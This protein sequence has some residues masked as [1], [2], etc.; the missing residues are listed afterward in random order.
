MC[1]GI[2]ATQFN[3]STLSSWQYLQINVVVIEYGVDAIPRQE[4]RG[5]GHG[6]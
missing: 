6:C 4:R 2:N 3:L 5:M 1:E